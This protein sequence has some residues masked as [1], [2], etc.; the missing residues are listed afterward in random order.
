MATRAQPNQAQAG[1]ILLVV[2]EYI[3]P[4]VSASRARALAYRLRVA[5]TPDTDRPA[6]GEPSLTFSFF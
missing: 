3:L 6:S 1:D 5:I 4:S 2:R